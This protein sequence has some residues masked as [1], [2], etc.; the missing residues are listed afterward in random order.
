ML[1]IKTMGLPGFSLEAVPRWRE[2][3]ILIPHTL[4]G[5]RAPFTLLEDTALD[6]ETR[7]VKRRK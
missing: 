1:S 3:G 4:I 2:H 6:I 7:A 5:K